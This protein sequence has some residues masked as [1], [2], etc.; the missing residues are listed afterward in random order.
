MS[1]HTVLHHRIDRSRLAQCWTRLIRF[2]A[3]EDGS[4]YYGEPTCGLSEDVGATF[5]SGVFIVLI[6]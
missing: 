3:S 5:Q 4:I 1:P 6:V 2:V